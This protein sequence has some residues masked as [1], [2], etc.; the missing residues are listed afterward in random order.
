[1]AYLKKFTQAREESTSATSKT[2]QIPSPSPGDLVVLTLTAGGTTS[3]PSGYTSLANPSVVSS[4]RTYA[5][6]TTFDGTTLSG[7][8]VSKTVNI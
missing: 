8:V 3:T 4:R 5:F 1:M 7:L 2:L 6:Y